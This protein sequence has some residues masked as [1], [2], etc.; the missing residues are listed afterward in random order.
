MVRRA[1]S[2]SVALAAVLASADARAVTFGLAV[3]VAQTSAEG[4]PRPVARAD[5]PEELEAS[6]FGGE[7]GAGDGHGRDGE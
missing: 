2:A 6:G 3:H 7:E 5:D 1:L 4:A